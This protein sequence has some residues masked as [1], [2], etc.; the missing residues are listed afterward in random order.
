MAKRSLIEQ[1]DEAVQALLAQ[2]DAPLPQ[3]DASLAPLLRV[4][5]ELRDLPREDFKMRLMTGLQEKATPPQPRVEPIPRGYRT[6]TPYVVVQQAAELIDFVKNAFG[7]KEVFRSTGTA[8]G[9]HCEMQVGDS[10]MMIGGG[11]QWKGTPMPT[12]LHLYV[13]DADSV[14]QSALAAGATSVQEPIDQFYGDREAGVHDLGGNHWYISTHK[15]TGDVPPGMNTL[16]VFLHPKSSTEMLAFLKRAFQ[17]EDVEYHASPEG[18]VH[19][20]SVK[21]GTSILEMGDAHGPHQPMPTM[22]YVYVDDVDSWYARALEAGAKS[23]Y[24]P[25]DQPYGDRNAGVEDPF[26]NQWYL[27][28]HVKDVMP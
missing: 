16:T 6:I 12:S 20:A 17:V 26:G 24:A 13:K 7:G 2:P 19:Y 21:I 22:F 18:M 8:G 1:L 4:A 27:A 5:A 28:T 11:G 3:V 25:A 10:K 23:M 15:A 9:I 14:Y